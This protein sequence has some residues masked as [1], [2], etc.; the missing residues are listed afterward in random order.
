VTRP[1][2]YE[3]HERRKVAKFLS[4]ANQAR[5]SDHIS[6]ILSLSLSLKES[7]PVLSRHDIWCCFLG[8]RVGSR[9]RHTE[10]E[11]PKA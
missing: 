11:P 3:T 7:L 2:I 8:A 6:P 4:R 1:Q 9:D 10:T 5:A